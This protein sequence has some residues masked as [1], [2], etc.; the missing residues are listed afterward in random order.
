MRLVRVTLRN[1]RGVEESTVRFGDGVTVVVGPNE[2]GKSS[3]AEAIRLLRTAK[4]SSRSQSVRDVKPAGRDVGPEAE[5]ELRTG[6]YDLVYRKRWLKSPMT[7][8]EVRAP[9]REQRSGDE[10]HQRFSALLEETVDVDLWEALEVLQGA[11][12][13]QP[14]LAR[15][16]SLHRA[17]DDSAGATGDHDALMS[18]VMTEYEK[19]FTATG[20][21]RG[22]YAQSAAEILDREAQLVALQSRSAEMDRYVEDHTANEQEHA[23]LSTLSIDADA[24]LHRAEEAVRAVDALRD[25]LRRAEEAVEVAE[26]AHGHAMRARDERRVLVTEEADRSDAAQTLG[27]R[28][29][30]VTSAHRESRGREE[31]SR[32]QAT[33]ATTRAHEARRA[34]D[35]AAAAL[36]RH[37]DRVE[38]DALAQRVRRAQEATRDRAQARAEHDPL[39]VDD[40]SLARLTDLATDLQVAEGA[41]EAAAAALVVRPLGGQPVLVDGSAIGAEPYEGAVLDEV[42]VAV[43]GVVEV[44]VRPGTPPADLDRRVTQ[45]REAFEAA[46]R[47]ADVDSLAAARSAHERRRDVAARLAAADASLREALDGAALDDLET[48]LAT[49]DSRN[50]HATDEDAAEASTSREDGHAPLDRDALEVAHD[51]ARRA[52]DDA[53]REATSSRADHDHA[54]EALAAAAEASVRARQERESAEHE[55]ERAAARLAA[56][57][58]GSSDGS[59]EHG[60]VAAAE[61]RDAAAVTATSARAAFEGASPETLDMELT[62]ARELVESVD[63]DLTRT[64]KRRVELQTLL[65]D[66]ATEGIHDRR[67]DVEAALE[68]ARATWQRLDRA[69][70]AV[71]LLK[72]TLVRRRDDAQRH[73]VAPF[74][75]RID[76]LGKVVFGADFEVEV[77]TDLA[78][79]T[80][81]L[82]GRTVPFTS[83][84]G[85]AKEQLALLGRLACAQLV[86][87]DEGAPV[88]LDDT[89]GFSDPARL[90]R[91]AVVLNDVGRTAQVVI[92]TCQPRRFES[93]GGAR[94]ERLVAR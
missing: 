16:S 17:L 51:A 93:V 62:N 84:S 30:E 23:R 92:L 2:V 8:L 69:A 34:A 20:K 67:V 55:H 28:L 22:D 70:Q 11:S 94:T 48:R 79:E 75:H 37:R 47:E 9:L 76:R 14:A 42:L 5:V 52:A 89:L 49:L 19:F 82:G 63:R 29:G 77:S 66:R 3:I 58:S 73:Y 85:G 38:R 57:R 45:A 32:L 25:G 61:S 86:D 56:A 80:R 40:A 46:L 7:E 59:L 81:T 18:A 26:R 90:E 10:A 87:V 12:L 24:R 39:R 68:V 53:D 60:V 33:A 31:E 91:L 27:A 21:P 54:R 72:E 74:K 6:P 35:D 4:S 50:R 1:F 71:A 83:L 13:D 15:I 65:D 64:D 44:L 41:R 43:E 36:A 88:I 78:I